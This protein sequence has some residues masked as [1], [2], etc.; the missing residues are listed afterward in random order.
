MYGR[1]VELANTENSFHEENFDDGGVTY[2]E[3]L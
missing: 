1:Y 3:L 2:E